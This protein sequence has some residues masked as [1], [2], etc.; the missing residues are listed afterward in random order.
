M[1]LKDI[2]IKE[3]KG[4]WGEETKLNGT[5]IIKTNNLNYDGTIDF[6]DICVRDIDKSKIKD[7]YLKQGD[8]L[9]EKSGGTKYHS[10]GYVT[11][12]DNEEEKYVCNNFILGLR[13]NEKIA[14]PKFIFYIL[15]YKYEKGDFNNCYKQTTGIQNLKKD[16]YL[17]TEINIPDFETQDKIIKI[18][19]IISKNRMLCFEKLK[20]FDLLVKSQ[21]IEMF[22]DRFNREKIKL[23]EISNAIIGL[24]YK[25]DNISDQGT[26]VLRSGNI[27]N[28]ELQIK[29]DVV[30]VDN[31]K[32]PDNKYIQENDILMCSRNG[33][34]R[35]VG[36][37]CLIN[38][39]QEKMSFGAYMTVIR[40]PYPY[41]LQS[42]FSSE[43][44][45]NQLTSV[46]TTSVNQITTGM[47]NN[48][49]VIKPTSEE[50]N[51]F[52]DFVKHI[53]KLKYNDAMMEVA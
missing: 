38:N 7:N 30:R 49:L 24:T 1:K 37:S 46:A 29:T 43:Y 35:L 10:V 27:Q 50:E 14:R 19:D 3:I 20:N 44:F 9:I 31:I 13:I 15:K 47:L 39:I 8:L 33:S 4:F 48:Y 25:P 16:K 42:F 17:D 28:N 21:F 22:G 11:Y 40:T 2:I 6:S 5:P 32:I 53:D 51:Q 18:L 41:F 26:I 52:A 34:A 23:S 45:K 12:Y 36:K